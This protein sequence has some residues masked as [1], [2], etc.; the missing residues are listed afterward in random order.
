MKRISILLLFLLCFVAGRAQFKSFGLIVGAGHTLVDVEEAINWSPL[1]DWDYFAVLIKATAEYEVMPGLSLVAEAGANRLY[2]WEYRWSD[3]YYSGYR[4]RSE[5][6]TNLGT[7][8]KKTWDKGFYLQG[9][10]A[11][12]VFNDGSGI[13]LGLLAGAGYELEIGDDFLLPLGFRIEPVLGNATPISLLVH[14]GIRYQ[15]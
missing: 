12:H 5:W 15:L 8:I 10:P 4:Y 13:V 2:Y 6:T 14:G 9:G 11:I 3:G 1:E 7:S